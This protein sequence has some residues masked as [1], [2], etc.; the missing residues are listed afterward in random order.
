MIPTLRLRAKV[1]SLALIPIL[2]LTLVLCAAT[3]VALTRLSAQQEQQIRQSLIEDR[4]AQLKQFVDVAL[5]AVGPQYQ[6]AAEGDAEARAAGVALLKRLTYGAGGYFWGYDS[7]A[8]RVFQ[9]T[10][11]ERIGEDFSGY[12]DPKGVYAIRELV[13]AGQ[14]GSHYVHYSFTLPGSS[15]IVPKIGYAHYLPKWNLVFGTSLNLDDIERDVQKAREAFQARINDLMLIMLGSALALLVAIALVAL[16]T[17]NAIVRP[18]LRIKANL[19]DMAAGDGNL[20][21]RLPVSSRDELGELATSFNRF[22]EKIHALVQQVAG[23]TQ[24]LAGLVADVAQ[25]AQRSEQAMGDQR[26]E[27]DQV[28]TAI[29]EMTAAAQEVARSAQRAADAAQETD[30][31]G[32]SAKREVDLCV[33]QINDLAGEVSSSSE[34][35]DTLSQDVRGIVGVLEVIRSIAEQTNLLALNAAIE[36]ARAGEAGRGFAVVADEVRALA[37]RTQQSTGEIQQMIDRLQGTTAGSVQA[38][39]RASEMAERT[40]GQANLAGQSLDAIASLI[41]TINS[42]NAQIA[43]AAEEQTAVAEEINRSVH[44]IA[45]SVDVVADDAARG[46]QTAGELNGVGE[47]LRQ[48]VGQFRI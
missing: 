42:M 44:Q 5:A 29:N 21:H 40:R 30:R 48:L 16:P 43:S 11:E 26:G 4:Q 17:S 31:E 10:S 33:A 1:L 28:A 47:R 39:Q 6:A 23:T 37:S 36:A 3:F 45:G 35:L 7:R 24:Q 20:T 12:Q 22:V 2:I 14:D 46:A 8:V 27:T 41:G 18:L 34:S 25:Q 9:G 19:D 15:Q 13:R 32:Q 38:M